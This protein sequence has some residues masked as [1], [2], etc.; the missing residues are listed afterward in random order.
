MSQDSESNSHKSSSIAKAALTTGLHALSTASSG[1][2]TGAK[3]AVGTLFAGCNI[4]LDLGVRATR[5]LPLGANGEIELETQHG[6]ITAQALEHGASAGF[7]PI[8]WWLPDESPPQTGIEVLGDALVDVNRT[9]FVVHAKNGQAVGLGG[10]AVLGA[11]AA[12]L[13]ASYPLRAIAPALHPRQLGDPAFRA[14]HGLRYAYVAGAMANGIGSEEI[15]ESMSRAGM[16][17]V[18]GA[19]GLSAGRVESAIDR[20]QSTLGE[21]AY[22]FNLIH[23]PQEPAWEAAIVELYLRRNVRLISASAYLDLTLPLIR[24]RVSGIHRD[25][26]GR[27]VCPNRVIAKVS[28]VEVARRF[29]SPPPEAILRRLVDAGDITAQQVQLA[30]RIPLATDLT[31]EADSGGHTDNRPLVALFPT[32][33]ALREEMQTKHAYAEPLRVGA[34]GGI[35]TPSSAAAAFALGAAYVLTGSVNQACVEAGTSQTVREMLAEAGQADVIMAPAADMFEMGVKLQVL[36]RGTLFPMRAAKLYELYRT[37]ASLE[38]LPAS[39]RQLL[40]KDFFRCPL[41]TAWK[42]TV[43]FFRSRDPGQITLAER[44]PKHKM[45]LVFRSYLGQS[46]NWANSGEPSRKIDYQIWC[47]PAMGAF[48]DWARGSFLEKP[49][50]RRVATIAKNILLGAAVLTRVQWLQAQGV[51]IPSTLR[52]FR[53]LQPSELDRCLEQ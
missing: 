23:S 5:R 51:E 20:L 19:A 35:S 13:E 15:V 24:Y 4:L 29:F 2:R 7:E 41:E 27:V 50:N 43:D 8:G 14:A 36:K 52:H 12:S 6:P 46:S 16:L 39:Q 47:G 38:E 25:L 53:P 33:L 42:E 17:G 18:F 9:L 1:A 37:Y 34:A 26:D 11:D 28:R 31:A 49:D 45:A 32:M 10:R 48:N 40:E 30:R 3:L 44:D 22:G 21:A